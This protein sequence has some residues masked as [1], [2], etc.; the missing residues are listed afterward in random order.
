MTDSFLWEK[1]GGLEY[2][3]CLPFDKT[4]LVKHCFSSR[5]GG[6]STGCFEAMNLGFS[7]DDSRENIVDNFKIICKSLG[8]NDK[9][10]VLTAQKHHCNIEIVT[11]EDAG[12]GIYK[13]GFEDADALIT[14]EKGLCL[15]CVWADCVPVLMLDKKKK[16]I[17][18]VHS[19]WRGTVQKIAQ[20]TALKMHDVY[21]S[22]MEDII[23]AI[24]PSIGKCHYEVSNDVAAEFE[25][26]F[27]DTKNIVFYKD[28]EHK[29]VDL[30]RTNAIMLESIGIPSE[31]INVS[32]YCTYCNSD[33]FFSHRVNGTKRGLCAAFL[34]LV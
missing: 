27:P 15:V 32:E 5:I 28:T 23:V 34:G 3:K 7:T 2:L 12:R 24:G 1:H 33:K 25:S 30:W 21:S 17:G 11:K 14:N 26:V 31:N 16:V 29:I 9:E 4:K 10:L 13:E 22:Q 18:A 6:V 19:G 20:K 8:V